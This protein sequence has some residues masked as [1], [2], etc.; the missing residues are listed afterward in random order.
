MRDWQGMLDSASA[1]LLGWTLIHSLWQGTLVALILLALLRLIPRRYANAR[2]GLAGLALAACVAL[3]VLTFWHLRPALLAVPGEPGRLASW[4]ASAE[5]SRDWRAYV[6]P[7]LPWLSQLW[8]LG[9]LLLTAKLGLEYAQVR[10][11]VRRQVRPAPA[12]L[13]QLCAGLAEALGVRSAW[14]LLESAEVDVP[15][16]VG[17]LKPVVLLPAAVVTGLKPEQIAMLLA[18]ELAHVRRHDYLVNLVQT[19]AEILLFFHPAVWWISRQMRHEREHCCD[20]IAVALCQDPIGYARTLAD[21]AELRQHGH[22]ALVLAATGGELKTRVTRLFHGHACHPHWGSRSLAALG[23]LGLLLGTGLA[24][25]VQATVKPAL[26]A[27]PVPV[28]AEAAEAAP[29]PVP[30]LVVPSP[31]P[32][33]VQAA[34]RPAP[35]R[36][37][38]KPARAAA[39]VMR[40]SSLI[41]LARQVKAAAAKPVPAPKPVANKPAALPVE[42]PAR[43]A[44][45][46]V[47]LASLVPVSAPS[48]AEVRAAKPVHTPHPD[49]PTSARRAGWRADV[50]VS[51]TVDEDGRVG[52]IVFGDPAVRPAFARAVR[53]ALEQ[54]RFEPRRQ[55]DEAVAERHSRVF[56]FG[57]ASD[58][59]IVTGSRICR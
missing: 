34:A 46:P 56:S 30:A 12:A 31:K 2:Y 55:N 43:P 52:D 27:E 47:R 37:S 32:A 7:V 39:K 5:A 51:F 9:V 38:L 36:E 41:R 21:T 11:L 59:R 3:P 18:H 16:V 40:E 29:K 25:R 35:E 33:P 20:D 42:A 13:Q 57:F 22:H 58:C 28:A 10:A 6:A 24:A 54:W 23:V 44:A 50:P 45:E 8:L 15:M 49:Y 4:A 1:E 19:L 14:R 26:A 48:L 17:W 53:A